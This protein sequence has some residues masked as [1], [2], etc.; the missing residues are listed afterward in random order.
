MPTLEVLE[1]DLGRHLAE[2]ERSGELRLS[3]SYCKP[4]AEDVGCNSAPGGAR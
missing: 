2:A 1:D 3:T 4:L